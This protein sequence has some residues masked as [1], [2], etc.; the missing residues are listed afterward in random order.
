MT[1]VY[2]VEVIE[3]GE[4]AIASRRGFQGF[5]TSSG[6][7]MQGPVQRDSRA[8]LMDLYVDGVLYERGII[9]DLISDWIEAI[10]V[11]NGI[12]EIP[13]QYNRTDAVCGVI[14]VWTRH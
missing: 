3:K 5:G 13:A 10:E 14:L 6:G 11:Y 2:L 7:V 8:C 12:S 9:D 4:Y 1:G